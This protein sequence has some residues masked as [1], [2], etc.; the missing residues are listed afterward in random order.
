[1]LVRAFEDLLQ[2]QYNT[3]RGIHR[4]A[5]DFLLYFVYGWPGIKH[6]LPL[7]W[8]KWIILPKEI[9][10]SYALSCG[11]LADLLLPYMIKQQQ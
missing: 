9:T 8:S 2:S 11:E 10:L 5:A 7:S 3:D 1:M 4:T 6:R